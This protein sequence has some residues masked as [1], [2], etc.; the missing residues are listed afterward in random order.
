AGELAHLLVTASQV[1]H[2]PHRSLRR[3]AGAEPF[4]RLGQLA[5]I[6]HLL[7]LEEERFGQRLVVGVRV[8]RED[9]AGQTAKKRNEPAGHSVPTV[10]TVVAPK[11]IRRL[12]LRILLRV[13]GILPR[14][15]R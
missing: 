2:S 5:L 10:E 12:R 13:A 6:E 3:M 15:E 8:G 9:D 4:A 14:R 11:R 7:A 1:E